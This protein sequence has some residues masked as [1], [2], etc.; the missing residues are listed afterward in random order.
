MRRRWKSLGYTVYKFDP[1]SKFRDLDGPATAAPR[2]TAAEQGDAMRAVDS[3]GSPVA[4]GAMILVLLGGIALIWFGLHGLIERHWLQALGTVVSHGPVQQAEQVGLQ[5]RYPMEVGIE[6]RAQDGQIYR[7]SQTVDAGEVIP[8]YNVG[9]RIAIRY[10]AED[11]RRSAEVEP[12]G[13]VAGSVFLIM[14][15][16]LLILPMVLY[17]AI[18]YGFME[19][20]FSRR[21]LENLSVVLCTSAATALFLVPALALCIGQLRF[22]SSAVH[23]QLHVIGFQTDKIVLSHQESD[24]GSA[25]GSVETEYTQFELTAPNQPALRIAEALPSRQGS[26]PYSAGQVLQVVYD[27]LDPR[28]WVRDRWSSRWLGPVILG[29]FGLLIFGIGWMMRPGHK[30]LADQAKLEQ[31]FD[32]LDSARGEAERERASRAVFEA[33]EQTERPAASE[34]FVDQFAPE[35]LG[36]VTSLW[37][38]LVRKGPEDSYKP[39]SLT[40]TDPVPERW[41]AQPGD[42]LV[43]YVFPS[44]RIG[45][46]IDSQAEP[47]ARVTVRA[48]KSP[49]VEP[50]AQ[51]LTPLGSVTLRPPGTG[52]TAAASEA[53]QVARA[54][55]AQKRS[56][57]S[58]APSAQERL[59]GYYCE[60]LGSGDRVLPK[61]LGLHHAEFLQWLSCPL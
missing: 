57:A 10:H 48:G 44:S 12:S 60:R 29:G 45:P 53:T 33:A 40:A 19:S 25:E 9:A 51:Q 38:G 55:V 6:F 43:Y 58:L 61:M 54:W 4:T 22:Q 46:G 50:L 34:T 59:R 26:R 8:D 42:G 47:I 56:F 7:L 23:G 28:H 15:G 3:I 36:P 27:P 35:K 24:S 2:E 18:Q 5:Y 17:G 14:V 31:A 39:Y 52:A 11:P 20:V 32:R 13:Y 21:P 37:K 49:L 30:E 41:P 16:L 1:D